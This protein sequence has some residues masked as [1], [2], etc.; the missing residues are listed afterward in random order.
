[1]THAG[2]LVAGYGI[3]FV[4]LGAYAWRVVARGRALSRALPPEE[5]RWR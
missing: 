3:T 4:A 2:Y 5:R 1:M